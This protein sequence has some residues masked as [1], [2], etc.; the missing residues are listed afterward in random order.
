MERICPG[1]YLAARE[2]FQIAKHKLRRTE[3]Q[4]LKCYEVNDIVALEMAM[5]RERSKKYPRFQELTRLY[6]KQ[7]LELDEADKVFDAATTLQ[8]QRIAEQAQLDAT[9]RNLDE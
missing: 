9:H 3:E 6:E 4:M 2:N 8:R 5:L 7:H 1:N